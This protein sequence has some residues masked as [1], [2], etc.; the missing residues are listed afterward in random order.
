MPWASPGRRWASGG[1]AARW[2]ADCSCS[3]AG[4]WPAGPAPPPSRWQM[5]S[6]HDLLRAAGL[7]YLVSAAGLL[8]WLLLGHVGLWRLLRRA[9]AAPPQAAALLAA[10]AGGRPCPR[11]LVSQRVRA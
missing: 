8:A 11:L 9:E 3:W 4:C 10:L 1:S 7:A 6:A 2:A 5:P